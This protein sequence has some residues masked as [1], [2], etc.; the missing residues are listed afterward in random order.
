M[1]E[2]EEDETLQNEDDEESSE[3]EFVIEAPKEEAKLH[4][5]KDDVNAI[6]KDIDEEFIPDAST[7]LGI[8]SPAESF[9]ESSQANESLLVA[10]ESSPILDDEEHEIEIS[11]EFKMLEKM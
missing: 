1:A 9:I 10:E 3:P 6:E 7:L 8:E 4:L 5:D 11:E 2:M